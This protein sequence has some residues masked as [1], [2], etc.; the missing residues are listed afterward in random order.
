MNNNYEDFVASILNCMSALYGY[1]RKLTG[2]ET[3]TEDLVQETVYKALTHY[4]GYMERGIMLYWLIHIMRNIHLNNVKR[5][6]NMNVTDAS[7]ILN[8]RQTDDALSDDALLLKD[9]LK[10]IEGFSAEFRV[11]L[12]M[13]IEGYRYEEIACR[14]GIPEGTVKSRI[15]FARKR[16]RLLIDK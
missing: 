16:L 3:E 1:G 7:D 15:H 12:L 5:K 14:L 2:D 10:I 8:L 6:S 11:P 4:E 9:V 13:F